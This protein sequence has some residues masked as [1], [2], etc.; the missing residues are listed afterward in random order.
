MV[1]DILSK[2]QRILVLIQSSRPV[3][4]R[5]SYRNNMSTVDN[6]NSVMYMPPLLR[7]AKDG[8]FFQ[9]ALN[10]ANETIALRANRYHQYG[11]SPKG[12]ACSEVCRVRH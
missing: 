1:A 12:G 9:M 7:A 2:E 6:P 8:L 4:K 11:I 5:S 3:E 10:A